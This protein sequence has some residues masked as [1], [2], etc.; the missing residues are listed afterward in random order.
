MVI[1]YSLQQKLYKKEKMGDSSCKAT[2][3]F[4]RENANRVDR[5]Y[6]FRESV[7]KKWSM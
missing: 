5:N 7:E 4:F 3:S 6:I 2:V 1:Y